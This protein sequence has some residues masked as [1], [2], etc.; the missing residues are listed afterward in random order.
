MYG[1]AEFSVADSFA[2]NGSRD[3]LREKSS[4]KTPLERPRRRWEYTIKLIKQ[5]VRMWFIFS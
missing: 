3:I 4:V 5:D 2:S 1:A